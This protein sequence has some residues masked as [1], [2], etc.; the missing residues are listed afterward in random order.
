M[1]ILTEKDSGDITAE[2]RV[3]IGHLVD[4]APG[5]S[6]TSSANGVAID[7]RSQSLND[8]QSKD[9]LQN[10]KIEKVKAQIATCT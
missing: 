2:E 7:R 6:H 9:D 10:I 5:P 8:E 3:T 4:D 1:I